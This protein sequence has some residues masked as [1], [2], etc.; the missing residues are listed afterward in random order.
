MKNTMFAIAALSASAVLAWEP[1]AIVTYWSGP[2]MGNL[3]L[4]NKNVTELKEEGF[5]VLW[6]ATPEDLAVAERHGVKVIFQD[7]NA[8]T[9]DALT[10]PDAA[11]RLK[12][13]IRT[14]KKSP[15]TLMYLLHDEPPATKFEDW[16]KMKLMVEEIDPERPAIINLLPMDCAS[17]YWYGVGAVGPQAYVNY[18][19]Q[20]TETFQPGC[21][22]YDHYQ[23]KEKGDLDDYFMN[24]NLVRGAAMAAGKPFVNIVQSCAYKQDP[25]ARV[26]TP[27]QMRYLAYTTA[28]YGARG[29]MYFTYLGC[30][31]PLR[32]GDTRSDNLKTLMTVNREFANIVNA[33]SKLRYIGAFHAGMV[34]VGA[35]AY[36]LTATRLALSPLPVKSEPKTTELIARDSRAGIAERLTD[37]ILVSRFDEPDKRAPEGMR[38]IVVNLDYVSPKKITVTAELP[39]AEFD[40]LKG[41]W[42]EAVSKSVKLVLPPG[43]GKLMKTVR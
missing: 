17:P 41:V 27:D 20:Y 40:A 23:F 43:G 16:A 32:T 13:A 18:L 33:V 8:F 28:A 10:K 9:L 22:M 5:N 26:P 11:E 38:W 14:A 4:T 15:A 37:T 35:T 29:I 36:T 34:S 39:L 42:G 2:G 12:A 7:H 25:M 1:E 6:A 31:K 30:E 19:R 3:R 24:L 21:Y